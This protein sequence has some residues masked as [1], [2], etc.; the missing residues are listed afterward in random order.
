[1]GGSAAMSLI[2]SLLAWFADP[3]HWQGSDG[4]PT[5]V[6]EHLWISAV[7]VGFAAL[8]AL[9]LGLYIGHTNRGA[10][11]MVSV[12][13]VGR[14][15][16]SLAFLA[17]ALPISFALNLGLGFWPTVI[18]LVP[19]AIPLVLI[20]TYAAIRGV[21]PDL[22]EAARG[23]GMHEIEVLQKV[24]APVALPLIIAGLRNAAVTVVATATLGAL[25]AGGGLG[26]YIIDGLARQDNARLL[27]GAI[28]V[29]VLSIATELA[30]SALER[31]VVSRGLRFDREGLER[32]GTG[33]AR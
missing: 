9:P 27:A 13:N 15:L 16:P 17:F 21:D 10:L 2:Q 28:L 25:V 29:A 5:R 18:A 33:G 19:L 7:S 26:R 1:M 11:A 22:I 6:A 14:A 4:I 20:N 8:V 12:M 24:E 32:L 3:A 30:F 31:A 23:M